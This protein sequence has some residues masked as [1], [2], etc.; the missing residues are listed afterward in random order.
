MPSAMIETS[1]DAL[2]GRRTPT[3]RRFGE[4]IRL[5]VLTEQI[6]PELVDEV[7]EQ[8][9]RVER[10]RRLTPAR[11]VVYFVLALC[12]FSSSESARP[13]GYRA[14]LRMLTEKLRHLPGG[15][16]QRLPARR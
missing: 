6:T 9:G 11:A 8:T 13:P 12:L 16:A 10:R 2:P 15:C 1:A 5:G 14:V 3:N 7:L 4:R